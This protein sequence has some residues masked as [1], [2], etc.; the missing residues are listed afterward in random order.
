MIFGFGMFPY[1]LKNEDY[2]NVNKKTGQGGLSLQ[3]LHI[4]QA[5][6]TECLPG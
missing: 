3:I 6:P 4:V 1:T 2:L 5:Y